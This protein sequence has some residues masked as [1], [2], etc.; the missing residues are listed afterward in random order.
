M[1]PPR[2][3]LADPDVVALLRRR[4]ATDADLEG[5][6]QPGTFALLAAFPDP[7]PEPLPAT[8]ASCGGPLEEV[9][10]LLGYSC[11]ACRALPAA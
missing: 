4:G 9:R 2:P 10:A 6:D 11:L 5:I 3:R 1:K 7:G 8:C